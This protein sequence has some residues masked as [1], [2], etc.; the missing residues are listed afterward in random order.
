[1]G[2][3]VLQPIFDVSSLLWNMVFGVTYLAGHLSRFSPNLF[4]NYHLKKCSVPL[5]YAVNQNFK[6]HFAWTEI[7]IVL[8]DLLAFS[9]HVPIFYRLPVIAI[10]VVFLAQMYY[11]PWDLP[12]KGKL[13]KRF[14]QSSQNYNGEEKSTKLSDKAAPNVPLSQEEAAC[15]D[16][17]DSEPV[18]WLDVMTFKYS[19]KIKAETSLL[20]RQK[21]VPFQITMVTEPRLQEIYLVALFPTLQK[22][23]IRERYHDPKGASI[24]AREIGPNSVRFDSAPSAIAPPGND[25][26]FKRLPMENGDLLMHDLFVRDSCFVGPTVRVHRDLLWFTMVYIFLMSFVALSAPITRY[27]MEFSP[28]M[29]P[30]AQQRYSHLVDSN[31]FLNLGGG[32]VTIGFGLL[33]APDPVDAIRHLQF[34]SGEKTPENQVSIK[35]QRPRKKRRA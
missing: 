26:K 27:S 15:F 12:F 31:H 6:L 23:E 4:D 35:R 3:A 30:L 10:H 13:R 33:L 5:A 9:S 11:L 7:G 1:M 20:K 14:D 19:K 17:L 2:Y 25:E 32:A 16:H 8:D 28:F 22:K 34:L 18:L 24:L 21:D 29:S